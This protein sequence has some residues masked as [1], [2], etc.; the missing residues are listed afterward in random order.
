MRS[1][2]ACAPK[3]KLSPVRIIEGALY[4]E[5][6]KKHVTVFN[7]DHFECLLFAIVD[8]KS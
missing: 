7:G 6:T 2:D 4:D 1:D 3:D 5:K 8:E